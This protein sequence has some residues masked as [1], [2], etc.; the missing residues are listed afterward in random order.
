MNKSSSSSNNNN[1]N[2]NNNN[3]KLEKPSVDSFEQ[4]LDVQY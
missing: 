3:D 4:T 2:N 1:N